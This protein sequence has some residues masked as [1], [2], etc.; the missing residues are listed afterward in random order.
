MAR[1]HPALIDIAAGRNPVA[2]VDDEALVESAL[3]H[4]MAGLAF[5]SAERGEL[6]I[7]SEARH[8][9]AGVKLAVAAHNA[10]VGKAAVE[11]IGALANHGW[12][13][14]LFK[15]LATAIRW[16]PTRGTRATSDVDLFLAPAAASSINEI[17][18]A[19]APGHG[20][21]GKAQRLV[22]DGRIQSFDFT[23]NDIWIDV[24]TDP[25]KVGVALPRLG[26]LWERTTSVEINGVPTPTLDAE[27]SMVQALIHLQ[28]D[29]FSRLHGFADIVRIAAAGVDWDWV[30]EYAAEAA[31]SVHVNEALR[32]VNEVLGSDLPYDAAASSRLWRAIWPE[33][34]ML[35]GQVG[36]TRKVRTHYWIP[37]TM[38]G[39]RSDALKWWSRIVVPPKDIV[40][41]MH[42]DTSGPYP[43]RLLQYRARLARER[44]QRNRE[45]RR[46]GAL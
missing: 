7:G 5:D 30:Q 16:Y 44:H 35:R 17:L 2:V 19:M 15:G 1:P 40:E 21:S 3:Q 25:I 6:E 27:A 14:A 34:S 43:V 4:R 18:A 36:L 45:Q 12:D 11:V 33:S 32:V 26:E 42:P 13:S 8:Q 38:P 31:L 28:K 20:L 29:R 46:Q 9:L 37:L 24:H 41:Y 39:R 23:W 22:D 10:R